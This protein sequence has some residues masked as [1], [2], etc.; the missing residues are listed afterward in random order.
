MTPRLL[1]ALSLACCLR[2]AASAQA[3]EAELVEKENLVDSQRA[4]TTWKPA[5]VGLQL[6]FRDKVRTGEL[7]RAA[8]RFTDR[9]MLRLDEFTVAEIVP[10]PRADGAPS[11]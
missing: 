3:P 1:L 7:S 9:T 10:P 2:V 6:L 5:N 11:L 4:S 8:V